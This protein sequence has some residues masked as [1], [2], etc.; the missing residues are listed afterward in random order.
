MSTSVHRFVAFPAAALLALAGAAAAQQTWTF[1]QT[2]TG[3]D[4]HWASPTTVNPN[5]VAY[6]TS[7]HLDLVEVKVKYLIFTL[8]PFD[9]TNQIPPEAQSGS[10]N[11]PGPAPI[12]LFGDHVAYPLPPAAPSVA[13][14]IAMGL[15]ATGHGFFDATNV[16]L[17]TITMDVPP[18][19]TITAQ[20]VSVHIKG[21]LTIAET[22]WLDRENALPGSLGAPT[23][24]GAGDLVAGHPMSVTVANALANASLTI[25]AGFS[26]IDAP[27]KGGFLVP[28]ADV[29]VVGLGTGPAGSLTLGTAWPAGVPAGFT[30]YVQGWIADPAGP[31]GFAATNGLAGTAQ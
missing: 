6:D 8:G 24:S 22:Q 12:T 5:S 7:Y 11:F 25:V 15:D 3:Q 26:E 29:L 13:A 2:T 10:G 4:I 18:F 1:D 23:L 17:G 28:S 21:S 14:D 27:F 30:F 20:I 19:G 16:T 31:K 9:I